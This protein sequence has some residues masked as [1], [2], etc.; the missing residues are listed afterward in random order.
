MLVVPMCSTKGV[1]KSRFCLLVVLD[2]FR[3]LLDA[4]V[5]A[6]ARD[7]AHLLDVPGVFQCSQSKV[8]DENVCWLGV[9]QVLF[10]G[11]DL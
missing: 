7:G 9:G 3:H 4:F 5:E 6:I 1:L 11:K 8:I 10:V 2:H